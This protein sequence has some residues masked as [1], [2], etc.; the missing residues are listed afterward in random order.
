MDVGT[1]KAQSQEKRREIGIFNLSIKINA[2]NHYYSTTLIIRGRG[3]N[4]RGTESAEEEGEKINRG[5]H[6]PSKI[7]LVEY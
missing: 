7:K 5:I 6:L 4:R 2:M 1:A 3:I